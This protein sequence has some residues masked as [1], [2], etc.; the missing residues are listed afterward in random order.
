MS[1][2]VI[3][4]QIKSYLQDGNYKKAQNLLTELHSRSG[5]GELDCSDIQLCIECTDC[6]IR[7]NIFSYP[8]AKE[9]LLFTLKLSVQAGELEWCKKILEHLMHLYALWG[10]YN[11]SLKCQ[12]LYQRLFLFNIYHDKISETIRDFILDTY[13]NLINLT[14]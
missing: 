2:N 13:R 9:H 11:E 10:E 1:T 8:D 14:V 5:A 3:K 4:N 12:T 7:E 6:M